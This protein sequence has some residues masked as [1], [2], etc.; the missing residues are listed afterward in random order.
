MTSFK[1]CFNWGWIPSCSKL[2]GRDRT[3]SKHTHAHT[4]RERE[5]NQMTSNPNQCKTKTSLFKAF[6]PSSLTNYDFYK[7]YPNKFFTFLVNSNFLRSSAYP[8][9]NDTNAKNVQVLQWSKYLSK[10]NFILLFNNLLIKFYY[11]IFFGFKG[12]IQ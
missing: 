5:T 6:C 2:F 4:E 8:T 12:E 1:E 11:F 7:N 9:S 10:F 3:S